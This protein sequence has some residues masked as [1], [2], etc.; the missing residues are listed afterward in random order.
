M[1]DRDLDTN[2]YSADEQRVA[3]FLFEQG[4]GGGDDPIGFLLASHASL[5]HERNVQA[6]EIEQLE[7]FKRSFDG[8]VYVK[9][10]D[11]SVL[12]K[13][14]RDLRAVKARPTREEIGRAIYLALY[15]PKGADWEANET[16]DVWYEVADRFLKVM[17]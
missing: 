9:N 16:K 11:F 12:H 13:E 3:D 8:H 2:P 1:M 4:T 15:Q 5:A 14:L 6:K 7:N 17:T 10:E